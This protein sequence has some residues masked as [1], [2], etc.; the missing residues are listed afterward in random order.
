M[1]SILLMTMAY[2]ALGAA[3]LA[4]S[5]AVNP[6]R[7]APGTPRA[8]PAAAQPAPTMPAARPAMDGAARRSECSR[9][10]Q[11]AKAANALE[12]TKWPTFYSKCN[13][14]LKAQ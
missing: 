14:E 9:R 13:A 1:K 5:P 3:A 2:F 12:G 4:Q 7:P 10:Y 11:A 8:A 6:L